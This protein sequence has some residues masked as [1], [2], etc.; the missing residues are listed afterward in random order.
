M[1][2]KNSER[3]GK[4]LKKEII[5]RFVASGLNFCISTTAAGRFPEL[6]P[7]SFQGE[8]LQHLTGNLW[9]LTQLPGR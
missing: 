9:S 4:F 1:M 6:K 5:G 2:K 8:E 3:N 7:I